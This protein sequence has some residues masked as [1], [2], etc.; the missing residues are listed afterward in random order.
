MKYLKCLGI[1][2]IPI[3][4]LGMI[5]TSLYYFDVMSG[6]TFKW[7]SLITM[8]ISILIGCMYLGKNSKSKGWFEGLKIGL[9]IS[10][11]FFLISFLG[12]ESFSLKNIIYYLVIILTSM[13]GS[14]FGIRNVKVDN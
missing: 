8:V 6:N 10:I 14:M 1:I 2:F 11:L 4:I 7:L 5:Y 9:G 13:L 12:F 3:L